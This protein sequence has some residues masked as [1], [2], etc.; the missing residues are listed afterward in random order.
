MY[1]VGTYIIIITFFSQLVHLLGRNT[2]ISLELHK[3]KTI[4]TL[5]C[6]NFLYFIP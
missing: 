3:I 4:L 1:Y 6:V 2:D 5:F